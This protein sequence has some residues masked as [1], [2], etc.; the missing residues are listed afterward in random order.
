M[1]LPPI[2]D[3]LKLKLASKTNLHIAD[4]AA[5]LANASSVVDRISSFMPWQDC[6]DDNLFFLCYPN[7]GKLSVGFTLEL[8]PQT[9]V[10]NDMQRS[11]ISLTTA[12]PKDAVLTCTVFASSAVE[13]LTDLLFPENSAPVA[14]APLGEDTKR[15]LRE[16][17]NFRRIQLN[18]GAREQLTPS[19]PLQVRH[20]RVWLSVTFPADKFDAELRRSVLEARASIVSVLE[21]SNLV[22]GVWDMSTA[23]GTI[24]EILNPHAVRSSSFIRPAGNPF[25]P[26]SSQ[27]MLPDTEVTIG[28]NK[29][30]FTDASDRTPVSGVGLTIASY[31]DRGWNLAVAA[32]MLGEF[33]RGGAQIPCPFLFSSIIRILDPA[34]EKVIAESNRMRAVQMSHTP[35]SQISAWYPEKARNWKIAADSFKSQGG[36]GLVSH[37]MFLL[38]P[39]ELEAKAVGDACTIARKL[40]VNLRRTTCLHSLALMS[41]LPMA[42]ERVLT[43][44]LRKMKLIE[45]RTIATGLFGVPIVTEWC[46]TG[47]RDDRRVRTPLLTLIGRKGQI[48]HVDFFAN[49]NGSYSATIV[50]K[51]GSGKSVAMNALAV[52]T[53]S[54]NGIVWIIDIGRS[55]EKTAS[56]F[57]GEFLIFDKSNVWNINPFCLL[58][59]FDAE[60]ADECFENIVS[61]L[62]ELI[63]PQKNLADFERSILLS[64]VTAVGNQLGSKATLLDLSAQLAKFPGDRR[65]NDMRSQLQPFCAG[66]L[67]KWFDGSGKPISFRNR[68]TVLELEGLSSHRAL[69][70]AVLMTLMLHIE[71]SM[72]R[73]RTTV[74]LVLIDEAWDLMNAGHSGRFI[75]S[76]FRRCRKHKGA[77]VVATQSVAD[78]FKSE[79]AEAAWNCADTRIFLRQDADAVA[80]LVKQGKFV[81]S[82]WFDEALPSLTTVRGCWSEMIVKVGDE[83]PAIGRLVLDRFTQV[84]FSSLPA[85][86]AAVEAWRAAGADIA[87]AVSEVAQGHMHPPVRTDP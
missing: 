8:S 14:F 72:A 21:Q 68:L 38:P 64:A 54:Q 50:G 87:T 32:G 79:T 9:G 19:A 31:P 62:A 70:Q 6:D 18:R 46:G 57:N 2:L 67:S 58:D 34:T 66:S 45:R 23:V 82:P 71:R 3:S 61:I 41:N 55:Y 26:I 33:Q 75:E 16:A 7:A 43:D 65:I 5:Q 11:L 40:G 80:S 84:L 73:D 30:S 27:I 13:F 10:T 20:F 77:F 76:G 17:A 42:A 69:R 12:L 60:E 36:L 85:E 15:L 22:A 29:I 37:M 53:L 47:V 28:K 52:S 83:P 51:P 49:V 74:K 48:M 56:L 35:L 81:S 86:H 59:K 44:D 4:G 1:K 63:S 39:K 78:F 25:A 24:A